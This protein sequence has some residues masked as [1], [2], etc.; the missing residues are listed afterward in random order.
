MKL[1]CKSRIALLLG[2]GSILLQGCSVS[3]LL[4]G[5]L[6]EYFGENTI[7]QSAFDDFNAFE[8]LLYEENDCG[9]YESRSIVLDDLL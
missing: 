4:G 1:L 6:N 8:Q 2:T 3:G 5:L 7:S 9:R